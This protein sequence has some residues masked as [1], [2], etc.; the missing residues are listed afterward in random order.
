MKILRY[1]AK[2]DARCSGATD[3]A[4]FLPNALSFHALVGLA[5]KLIQKKSIKFFHTQSK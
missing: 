4:L 5:T 3:C 1:L 2:K